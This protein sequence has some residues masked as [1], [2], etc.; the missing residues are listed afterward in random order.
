M[1]SKALR[2]A[3]KESVMTKVLNV[4][5]FVVCGI[6]AIGVGATDYVSPKWKPV[7]LGVIAAAGWL[8][9]HW[10]FKTNPDGTPAT[11]AYQPPV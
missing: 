6:C 4:A 7:V 11:T 3:E 2:G 9:A 1:D 5:Y 10:N 8:K